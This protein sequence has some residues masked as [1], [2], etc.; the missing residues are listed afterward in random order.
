MYISNTSMEA[1]LA[2]NIH[3]CED[4]GM[5]FLNFKGIKEH[6]DDFEHISFKLIE[7]KDVKKMC[8]GECHTEQY[9]YQVSC[10]PKPTDLTWCPNCKDRIGS[11]S[12]VKNEE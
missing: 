6:I 11:V 3:E 1:F 4:C 7:A 12:E 2:M 9:M 10:R 5:I 8:C